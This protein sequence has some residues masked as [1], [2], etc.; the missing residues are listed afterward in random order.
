MQAAFDL[1]VER[2]DLLS[3]FVLYGLWKWTGQL[4][5]RAVLH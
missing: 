1:G 2:I 4:I 5:L 3:S